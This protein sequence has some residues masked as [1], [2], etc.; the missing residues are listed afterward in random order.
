MKLSP[1]SVVGKE[2]SM[3]ALLSVE[4]RPILALWDGMEDENSVILGQGGITLI[5]RYTQS[6]AA[7]ARM[8][9]LALGTD[10]CQKVS[11]FSDRTTIVCRQWEW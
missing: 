2:R 4:R 3:Y 11:V 9:F 6:L 7:L 10:F 1:A 8:P 5:E